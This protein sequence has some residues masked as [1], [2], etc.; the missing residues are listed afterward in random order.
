M[1][2]LLQRAKPRP[3]GRASAS[4]SGST[5]AELAELPLY[6][7]LVQPLNEASK[8]RLREL[9]SSRDTRRITSNIDKSIKHLQT[10]VGNVNDRAA[11][12]R[13]ELQKRLGDAE[14]KG[15]V[16]ETS[17]RDTVEARTARAEE[18]ALEYTKQ[19]EAE[20]RHLLDLRAE[21][22]DEDK[23]FASVLR[24]LEAQAQAQSQSQPRQPEAK[25]SSRRMV[26]SDGEEM[27]IDEEDEPEEEPERKVPVV[28]LG[29]MLEVARQE[30]VA[31]Y[32][33]LT[34]HQ[35][36][37]LN[38]DYIQFKRTWHDAQHQDDGVPLPDASR[39]FDQNGEPIID[40]SG[41]LG[42]Q[43]G[44]DDD[45]VVE[46][47]VRS[48][49]CPLSLQ[50]IKEPY[51]NKICPHTFDKPNILG[52][53]RTSGGVA[54]CPVAGCNHEFRAQDFFYDEVFLRKCLRAQQAENTDDS[55]DEGDPDTS[56]AVTKEVALNLKK[57]K[58]SNPRTRLGDD[59]SL[60]RHD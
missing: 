30:Q 48:F 59:D 32:A 24:L 15:V 50:W 12:R 23:I 10:G 45:I 36:Y 6:E 58:R 37:G 26:D 42:D 53:I 60:E 46:R 21:L 43:A 16:L 8:R 28:S 33:K 57:E 5:Q 49:R 38:N 40:V 1:P 34:M 4:G 9:T 18:T 55:D 19:T 13:L 47:E 22:E 44:D 29:Q 14:K 39:W 51:S 35:R 54:K 3:T 25:R 56:M 7:P 17:E 20:L 2:R 27:D 11:E 41:S 52:Y 31:E